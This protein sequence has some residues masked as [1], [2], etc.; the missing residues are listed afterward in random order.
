METDKSLILTIQELETE[1]VVANYFVELKSLELTSDYFSC[2]DYP[3]R[4]YI[5]FISLEEKFIEPELEKG[6]DY[7]IVI[8]ITGDPTVP[9]AGEKLSLGYVSRRFGFIGYLEIEDDLITIHSKGV[10]TMNHV[11]QRGI[12]Q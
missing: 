1:K 11:T 6:K 7:G 3:Y 4:Y 8:D 5:P 2:V 9:C 10:N 12:E